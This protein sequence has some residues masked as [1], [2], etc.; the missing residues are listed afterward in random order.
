MEFSFS[1]QPVW[2]NVH[3]TNYLSGFTFSLITFRFNNKRQQL[4]W[5]VL[6]SSHKLSECRLS[7]ISVDAFLLRDVSPVQ[8][9]YRSP[10]PAHHSLLTQELQTRRKTVKDL[11]R[12]AHE[13]GMDNH[14]LLKLQD[15]IDKLNEEVNKLVEKKLMN[16]HP[17]RDKLSL[18]RQQVCFLLIVAL[19]VSPF[20]TIYNLQL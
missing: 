12:V 11:R 3:H 15:D 17:V 2:P 18:F 19:E 4:L 13:S 9:S 10:P 1:L 5:N 6:N 7:S 20:W 8:L 14:D 16:N